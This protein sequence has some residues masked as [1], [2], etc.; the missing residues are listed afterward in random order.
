[1][2]RSQQGLVRR[3]RV[4]LGEKPPPSRFL[5]CRHRDA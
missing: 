4:G 3:R 5:V 2:K 1:L